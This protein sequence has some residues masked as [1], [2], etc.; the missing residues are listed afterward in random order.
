MRLAQAD[1]VTMLL[2]SNLIE[3]EPSLEA[4]SDAIDAWRFLNEQPKLTHIALLA[5]HDILMRSRTTISD[6]EKGAYRKIPVYIGGREG[7]N[8]GLIRAKMDTLLMEVNDKR[9]VPVSD[10]ARRM[11]CQRLHVEFEHI[12]PFVDGNGRMGRMIYNW[13]RLRLQLPV[14]II[15]ASDKFAYY[16]WFDEV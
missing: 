4:L 9:N 11:H 13:Q 16:R 10:E 6:A 8:A 3:N 14:H 1:D 2:Q 15:Y 12:H 5:A 7:I